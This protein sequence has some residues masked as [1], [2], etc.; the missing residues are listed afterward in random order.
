M[1]LTCSPS[2]DELVRLR[3]RTQGDLK[4][5]GGAFGRVKLT[6]HRPVPHH[7]T[8]AS[9]VN[10][11]ITDDIDGSGGAETVSFGFQGTAY[12]VDLAKKNRLKLE[13]AL[14]PYIEAARRAPAS[15]SRSR[16]SDT[17]RAA[18]RAWAKDHGLNVSDRG[19]IAADVLK[20]Y[21]ASH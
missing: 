3:N 9:I 16:A 18:V 2:E 17:D 5:R 1:K 21:E 7:A 19:R 11:T 13:R 6:I 12:E 15:R 10:V 4:L 14:T 20:Q 8:M